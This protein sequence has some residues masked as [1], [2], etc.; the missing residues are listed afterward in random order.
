MMSFS[1]SDFKY[2]DMHTHF[3]PTEI[4][5]AIWTYF[6]QPA[7]DGNPQG[8]EIHYKLSNEKLVEI[9]KSKNIERYTTFNYAHKAGIAEYI[10]K[11]TYEFVKKN[12]DA[13]AFGCISPEDKNCVDEVKKIFNEYNFYGI[14]L[15]L[16]VQ[17]FYP[18]DERMIKVYDVVLDNDKWINFHVGTAPYKNQYVGYK[19]FIK[20]LEKFPNVNV[21]IS[22]LGMY[23][24]QK[25]FNL[26]D[27]YEN[28]FLDTTMVYIPLDL[29]K[30]WHKEIKLPPSELLLSYQDRI[31]FGS[32]FPNIP[33]EYEVSTKGLLDLGLPRK[34]YE[35]IFYN[36]AKRILNL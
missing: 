35:D 11:W 24:F 29:F 30:K 6:E 26:L 14:K 4:F 12:K 5:K 21:V 13:I 36:N 34:F 33:Y 19:N 31:L 9:L 7:K 18:L 27:S 1:D 22:H 16:L 15:Q 32:D 3:F 23:E 8:W 20:F 17:N 2:I 28:L 10:N 25:F